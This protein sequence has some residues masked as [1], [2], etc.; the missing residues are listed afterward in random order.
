MLTRSLPRPSKRLLLLSIALVMAGAL[1][2]RAQVAGSIAVYP[3]TSSLDVPGSR[4]FSAYVPISPNT[5]TWSVNGIVG[6]DA[7]VGTI[8]PAGLYQP[9]A[10]IPAANVLTIAA[11]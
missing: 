7:T 11:R 3:T 1:P 6:G 5:I 9:P 8:S 10:V 2:A 4:Q